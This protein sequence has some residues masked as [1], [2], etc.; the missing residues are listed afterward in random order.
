MIT[1]YATH[2]VSEQ[3]L[4]FDGLHGID[5]LCHV[6]VYEHPGRLPVVIAGDLEDNPGTRL[7]NGIELV[8]HAVQQEL[9][10]DGREF[11]L[12][13]YHVD[14][15]HFLRVEFALAGNTNAASCPDPGA[16]V[17]MTDG[18]RA[19]S[20]RRPLPGEFRDPRWTTV[21]DIERLTGCPVTRWEQGTYTA[22]NVGGPR[23]EYLRMQVAERGHA[24]ADRLV[25]L[26]GAR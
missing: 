16:S 7:T 14:E 22:R 25:T 17:V 6:R 24:A 5:G 18:Q 19:S 20:A 12:V 4:P 13:E 8:A 21:D 2:A 1:F 10:P 3:L 11:Q 15:P 26:L 23:G 9:L